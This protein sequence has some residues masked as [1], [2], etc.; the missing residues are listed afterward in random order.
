MVSDNSGKEEYHIVVAVSDRERMQHGTD[1]DLDEVCEQ[2]AE[3]IENTLHGLT[4]WSHHRDES[5]MIEKVEITHVAPR[6]HDKEI[7]ESALSRISH[8][9]NTKLRT[10]NELNND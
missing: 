1:E 10:E 3:R 4:M 6:N 5:R 7:V 8:E 2:Y 9:L